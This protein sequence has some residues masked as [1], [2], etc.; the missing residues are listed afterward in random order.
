VEHVQRVVH[1]VDGHLELA[2]AT[3]FRTRAQ[4]EVKRRS[5]RWCGRCERC[6]AG[7]RQGWPRYSLHHGVTSIEPVMPSPVTAWLP[8]PRVTFSEVARMAPSIVL[9]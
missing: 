2:C 7:Q 9:P 6:D 3:V 5:G 4:R 8:A 1:C